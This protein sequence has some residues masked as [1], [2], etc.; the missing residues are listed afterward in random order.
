MSMLLAG[1][2][3]TKEYH[4][5]VFVPLEEEPFPPAPSKA[6]APQNAISITRADD[7]A[8]LQVSTPGVS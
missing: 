8:L 3:E 7:E 1:G 2:G 4:N 5:P 6:A